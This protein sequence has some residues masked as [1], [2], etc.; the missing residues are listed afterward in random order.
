MRIKATI[1]VALAF[2]VQCFENATIVVY[3]GLRVKART[4]KLIDIIFVHINYFKY[5]NMHTHTHTH[6]HTNTHTETHIVKVTLLI[7]NFNLCLNIIS[8]NMYINCTHLCSLRNVATYVCSQ[9][10]LLVLSKYT[11]TLA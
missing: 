11:C 2:L 3:A 8:C 1:V 9:K 6:T 10:N 5:H 4:Q 7:F